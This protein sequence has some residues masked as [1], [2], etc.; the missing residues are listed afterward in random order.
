MCNAVSEDDFQND[1]RSQCEG[2]GIEKKND[3][4]VAV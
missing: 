3:L 4:L 2:Q 1:L